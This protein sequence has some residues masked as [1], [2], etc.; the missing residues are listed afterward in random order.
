MNPDGSED[1]QLPDL[2]WNLANAK[3]SEFYI[4]F[5]NNSTQCAQENRAAIQAPTIITKEVL[6]MIVS[7]AN[8]PSLHKLDDLTKELNPFK[9]INNSTTGY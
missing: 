7:G 1:D 2:Y 8:A 9:T 5:Q 4:A 6:E 3:K